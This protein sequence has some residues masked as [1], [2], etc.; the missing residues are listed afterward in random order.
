MAEVTTY[1]FSHK[2]VV[3]ALIRQQDIHEG[4]WS[5]TVE[6]GLA[7]ANTGPG[8]N[9]LNPTAILPLVKL[10]IAKSK[11]LTNLSVD[12]SVVNPVHKKT[13]SMQSEQ[14]PPKRVVRTTKRNEKSD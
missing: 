10:G 7:V 12:A 8:P 6:Y 5:L 9:D 11:E 3:E 4:I 13:G 14:S 2:E 1:Q